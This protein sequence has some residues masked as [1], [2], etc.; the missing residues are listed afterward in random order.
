MVAVC[1]G[2][3]VVETLEDE[4]ITSKTKDGTEVLGVAVVREAET[5]ACRPTCNLK[6]VAAAD[7]N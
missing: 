5:M 6:P 2:A 7:A 3:I 1:I 4:T